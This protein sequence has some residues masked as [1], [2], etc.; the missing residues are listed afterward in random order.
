MG[1]QNMLWRGKSQEDRFPR[2]PWC[3]GYKAIS[4]IHPWGFYKSFGKHASMLSANGAHV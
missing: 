1:H 2:T 4:D 3:P